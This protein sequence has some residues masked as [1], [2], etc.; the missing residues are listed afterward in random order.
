MPKPTAGKAEEALA[1]AVRATDAA[2]LIVRDLQR[3]L[4]DVAVAEAEQML[5]MAQEEQ[6]AADQEYAGMLGAVQAAELRRMNARAA[7][8]TARQ[9]KDT[10]DQRARGGQHVRVRPFLG[11]RHWDE[12]PR[13]R[14]REYESLVGQGPNRASW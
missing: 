9:V 10:A 5:A 6:E 11:G 12:L 7:I 1:Q 2:V 3:Q 14:Q 8:E 13:K 4:E